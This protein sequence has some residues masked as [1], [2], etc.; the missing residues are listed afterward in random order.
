VVPFLVSDLFHL[1]LLI[2]FPIMALW[3]PELMQ[4]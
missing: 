2:L 1:V 4:S 3:L